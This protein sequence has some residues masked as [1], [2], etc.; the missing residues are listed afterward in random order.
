MTQSAYRIFDFDD[1]AAEAAR[2]AEQTRAMVAI[3]RP[4]L[5]RHGLFE[6]RTI[7]DVGSGTGAPARWLRSLGLSV[8]C[9]DAVHAAVARAEEPRVVAAGE[10][11][12]F[13]AR[14][15]DAAF[16]RLSLQHASDP[17]AVLREMTRVA[18]S[19]VLVV[20]TDLDTFVVHPELPVGTAARATW[21]EL[22][23]RRGADA[24]IGRRL[25]ALL[26]ET[27]LRDVRVD[28]TYVTSDELGRATFAWMLLTPHVRV[29]HAGDPE[30]LHAAE[31]ELAAWVADDR[32][33]GAAALFVASGRPPDATADD[34][35]EP[36]ASE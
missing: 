11:L 27:G 5:E 15:F 31:S 9:V 16:A 22:A 36:R 13:G 32:S 21:C 4:L 33:F 10:H 24:R 34:P 29:V 3:E 18:R 23:A 28:A 20:D 19:L 12:P 2:L 6:E 14:S 7:V 30:R 17:G 1:P 35:V 25:R 8:T 26:V